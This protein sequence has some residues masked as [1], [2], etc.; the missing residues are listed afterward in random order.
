MAYKEPMRF[1]NKIPPLRE[2]SE[3]EQVIHENI[4]ILPSIVIRRILRYFH[5]ALRLQAVRMGRI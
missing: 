1:L 2:F 3:D 4:L 5:P